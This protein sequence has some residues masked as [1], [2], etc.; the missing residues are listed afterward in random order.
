[1]IGITASMALVVALLVALV[2]AR[3]V[4]RPIRRLQEAAGQLIAGHFQM[5]P[6]TGPTEIAQLAVHFNHMGLT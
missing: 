6:P 4:T 5:V 3:S 2:S 1:M